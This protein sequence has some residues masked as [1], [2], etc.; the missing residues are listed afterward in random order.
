MNEWEH[1]RLRD[2]M[3]LNVQAIPLDPDETYPVVG[4][5][6]RGRGLLHRGPTRGSE[7]KYKTL[8]RIVAGRVVYSR[9]KAFEGAITVAPDNLGDAYASQEFP[10]FACRPALVPAFFAL[11]TTTPALWDDLKNLSTGMGGRRERVK[12]ADFLTLPLTLPTVPEQRRI[13]DVMAAVDGQISAVE[14]ELSAMAVFESVLRH[15]TFGDLDMPS[16]RAGDKFDMLLGRQKSARQSVGDHVLPYLRA[17]NITDGALKLDD[18]QTMN[19]DPTEQAKY[20]L[21]ADDILLVEGGSIGLAA[22][23]SG[24]IEGV[25][26]FDKHVIRLRARAGESTS[27]FALQW[28]RWSHESGAFDDQ[29]TGITIK[30]LGFGRASSMPVPDLPVN[31]QERLMEPLAAMGAAA[32]AID[33]ELVGLRSFR[34]TLLTALLSRKISIPESYDALLE[35]TS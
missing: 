12:P 1:V 34:S 6:N 26:G 32:V 30:A 28:A 35:V 2:V 13:V 33:S 19:F 22:R 15:Q 21:K 20:G 7:T 4:V 5:L 25:V 9:L 8:N 18:V 17:A 24:E 11:I 10:T 29:A 27:E 3:D 31:D 16:V 23:W 14:S